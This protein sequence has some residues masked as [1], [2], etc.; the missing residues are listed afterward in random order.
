AEGL[1]DPRSIFPSPSTSRICSRFMRLLSIELAVIAR[2]RGSRD[3]TALRL[4]LVP[5]IHARPW[6]PAPSRTSSAAA[7]ANVIESR[8]ILSA[9]V[10]CLSACP[11]AAA[12]CLR[13]LPFAYLVQCLWHQQV[14]L[15]EACRP[16]IGS[17][18]FSACYGVFPLCLV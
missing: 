7:S 12:A 9:D 16:H 14:R 15:L 17:R 1:P 5:S 8:I 13:P 11:L 10:Q 18:P 4:P 2:R 6:K 3:R